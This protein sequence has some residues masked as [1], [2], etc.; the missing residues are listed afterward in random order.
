MQ[1]DTLT[2]GAGH[3][4]KRFLSGGWGN[5]LPTVPRASQRQWRSILLLLLS[6]GVRGLR[7]E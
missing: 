1:G 7:R 5:T 3:L 6:D 4:L 2:A